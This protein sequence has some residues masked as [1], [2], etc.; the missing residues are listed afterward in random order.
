VTNKI[1]VAEITTFEIPG[2]IYA[3]KWIQKINRRKRDGRKERKLNT[4]R[5][6]KNE[7][8]IITEA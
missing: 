2:S 8:F 1:E 6:N 5:I 4:D 3:I 7:L